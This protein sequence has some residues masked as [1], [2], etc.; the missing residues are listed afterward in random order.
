[1]FKKIFAVLVFLFLVLDGR[2]QQAIKIDA[3]GLPN[4]YK[5]SDNFYRGAQPLKE[6]FEKLPDYGV[7]TIINLRAGH[8]DE[9]YLTGV[10][11]NYKEIK[12]NAWDLK[13]KHIKSFL[14]IIADPANLP[15]FIHCKHGADRT[16][17]MTAVY[18]IVVEGW[19]KEDAVKEMT[20]GPFGFHAIWANLPKTINA[21]DVEKLR[22][23][24]AAA[25][26]AA[27][28][29]ENMVRIPAAAVT[30]PAGY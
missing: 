27:L 3:A 20:K 11:L 28:K 19:S 4:F 15:V 22:A 30:P 5:I 1:M 12:I 29:R 7:K 6:G 8:S 26:N 24:Y 17:A 23:Y 2:A 10:P 16:G 9:K 25:R 21:L 13:E 14:D 18:R